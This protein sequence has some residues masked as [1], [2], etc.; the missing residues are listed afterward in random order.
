M[1]LHEL[2]KNVTFEEIWPLIKELHNDS[3]VE[4][5]DS[6]RSNYKEVFYYVTALSSIDSDMRIVISWET[7]YDDPSD[8]YMDVSGRRI[9]NE[10]VGERY[11]LT[12]TRWSEWL[13]MD[14]DPNSL[15]TFT[16]DQILAQCLFEMTFYGF[17]EEEIDKTREWVAHWDTAVSREDLKTISIDE[18]DYDEYCD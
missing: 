13:G 1:K 4:V 11:C 7:D 14:V 15:E 6:L 8:V 2:F 5:Y 16:K 18:L 12:L 17:T 10:D 9:D 3:P